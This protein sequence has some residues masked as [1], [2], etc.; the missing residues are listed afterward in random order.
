MRSLSGDW[1][2]VQK[3]IAYDISA[4]EATRIALCATE[5]AA[6]S[7][8][9]FEL[10]F[11]GHDSNESTIR[12][13]IRA[14]QSNAVDVTGFMFRRHHDKPDTSPHWTNIS[15]GLTD[16]RR[17]GRRLLRMAACVPVLWR[18]RSA[19]RRAD[20]IYA[21]NIDMLVVASIARML[22]RGKAPLFYEA[23]DVHPA[24]TNPGWKGR[25]LRFIERRMLKASQLLV[26][27]SPAFI[28]HYFAPIQKYSGPCHLLENKVHSGDGSD[29]AQYQRAESAT[30]RPWTIG[31]FGVIRCKRSLDILQDIAD[32]FPDRVAVH[33][34]GL[35]S[36]PDG[37]TSDLLNGVA[38]RAGNIFNF[39]TYQNPRDLAAIYG[40][41]DLIW[42]VDFS[43]S[44]AN[45]DWLIPNR[46]Y[47]GGLYGLPAIA[48]KGTAT[49]DII[50][51]NGRGWSFAEPFSDA[52]S[53]FLKNLDLAT[54]EDMAKRV[55]QTDRSAFVDFSD[56]TCLVGEMK[57]IARRASGAP[58]LAGAD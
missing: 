51:Q 55:R 13:R 14:L 53:E 17:Y 57:R 26:V 28:E 44:H 34:R 23:L 35:P 49:G 24:F 37:I 25:L 50:D 1:R 3:L 16:D 54:Y 4:N 42:A 45:S 27:S 11:F 38:T 56:T 41:V 46:L 5:S 19:I 48:R 10:V 29:L 18:N 43:A 52:V 22:A 32:R 21:R 12:K 7:S 33:I 36:E 30:G 31:W 9:K 47:E 58:G 39:G 40:A 15:L 2:R 20:A 6:V 8:G